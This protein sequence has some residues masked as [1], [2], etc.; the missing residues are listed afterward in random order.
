MYSSIRVTLGVAGIAFIAMASGCGGGPSI[1][2]TSVPSTIEVRVSAGAPVVGATVTVY[3]ISDATG[4]VNNAAGAGGVLGSAGPTDATGKV[5]LAVSPYSGPVQI[6]AGGPA[7]TY[8][9]PTAAAGQNGVGPVIQVPSSFLF[10]SFIAKFKPGTPVPLTFLTT[11]ADRAALAFAHGLHPIHPSKATISE[12]LAARD[13][14]F[15]THITNAPAAW[16]PG[17]LRWTMPAPLHSAPQ[18]LVD[19]AFA[20][21]FDV[22]LNQLARDTAAQAGYGDKGGLTAPTLMQLLQDDI[23]A[24]GRLDGLTFGGRTVSTAG[25]TPVVMDAQFLHKP[26]AVALLGWVR[27]TAANKS[28]ISDADLASALVFKTIVEDTSDLFGSFQVQPIDP[29]DRTAPALTL[30]TAPSAY[31]NGVNVRIIVSAADASGTKA[32]YAQVGATRLAANLIGGNWQVDVFLQTVGHNTIT[33]WGEDLAQPTSN[34]GLGHGSPFEIVLDVVFDPD[35]PRATYDATVASYFDERGITVATGADGLALVPATYVGGPKVP[36]TLGGDIFKSAT[37]VAAGAPFDAHELETTNAGNIPVLRFVVP[38]NDKVDSPIAKAEYTVTASCPG[39]GTISPVHGIL[40]P[41][42]NPGV[43]A[44]AFDL[45]LSSETV[46]VVAAPPGPMSLEVSLDLADAAGNSSK[47]GGFTFTFH[48]VGPP[49]AVTEDVAFPTYNDPRS[50][51][52]YRVQGTAIAGNSYATL[53]DPAASIF[54]GG[55]VRLVRFVVS[56]PS[57]QP[58]AIRTDFAQSPTGSWKLTEGWRRQ[59]FVDQPE[60]NPRSGPDPGNTRVIDGFTFYQATYWAIPYGSPGYP[61]N[62]LTEVGPHPC[63]DRANGSPA[64]RLGDPF[65]RWNCMTNAA[66][67]ATSTGVFAS[68]PVA[69]AV[70]RGPQQ[71]GGEVLPPDADTAGTSVIVPGAAGGTPGTLVVYATRPTSAQRTRPLRVNVLGTINSY[72]TY[73]YEV[74]VYAENWNY[75]YWGGP[76]PYEVYALYKSGEYLVGSSESLEAALNVTTQGLSGNKVIGE[77]GSQRPTAVSRTIANH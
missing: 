52:P 70:F 6:V 58:V 57:P 33:I 7:A 17:A 55:Q 56:N 69:P 42:P 75:Y 67:L 3:A 27:N 24:D 26:L 48:V 76:Y 41:S 13:P 71:G 2:A 64:H 30:V 72:E 47:V 25:S 46:P 20:A 73:D 19:A 37:R 59:A 14:L 68:G 44:L 16:S 34:S 49:V 9:D 66:M 50:T 23:D 29:L 61:A 1:E 45:P 62:G 39:C 4:Q 5:T 8:A 51:Y 21:L 65:A 35:A 28:G 54:Y 11:L 31:S 15:V 43:G 40:L 18:S 10:T 60:Q 32:V 53:F 74:A 36:V 38:Y 22:A 63:G 12:A 77:S